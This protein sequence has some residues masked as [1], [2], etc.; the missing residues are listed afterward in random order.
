MIPN[1]ILD[2]I[3]AW[4][5]EGHSNSDIL[6]ELLAQ[7]PSLTAEQI[8]KLHMVLDLPYLPDESTKIADAMT[9]LQQLQQQRQHL[10]TTIESRLSGDK[11]PVSL[12]NLYR[13]VLRDQE[14][15]LWKMMQHQELPVK[16][17]SSA[18]HII[19]STPVSIGKPADEMQQ[20]KRSGCCRFTTLLLLAFL[21]C[22]TACFTLMLQAKWIAEPNSHHAPGIQLTYCNEGCN[23]LPLQTILPASGNSV[24]WVQPCWQ[25]NISRRRQ[26]H[27]VDWTIR[28]C[29]PSS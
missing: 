6:T 17:A 13:G 16:N 25:Q 5:D 8:E 11:V 24:K 28:Q 27:A 23:Y 26:G 2:Q 18:K 3:D 7:H 21:S 4:H 1:A 29:S 10:L 14:A 9:Q 19:P 20:K 22:L 12:F 15:S